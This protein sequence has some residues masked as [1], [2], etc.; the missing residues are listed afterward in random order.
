[1]MGGMETLMTQNKKIP[2]DCERSHTGVV[3]REHNK[4]M[5]IVAQHK[6]FDKGGGTLCLKKFKRAFAFLEADTKNWPRLLI[7]WG[8]Q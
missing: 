5:V 4:D 7:V 1:M 8:Y 3:L 6:G 2:H